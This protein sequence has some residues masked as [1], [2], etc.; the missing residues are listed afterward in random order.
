MI[1]EIFIDYHFI[2]YTLD[3]CSLC[4]SDNKY[5]G[6]NEFILHSSIKILFENFI[7]KSKTD[8][9][10]SLHKKVKY[11]TQYYSQKIGNKEGSR[12]EEIKKKCEKLWFFHMFCT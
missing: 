9:K 8:R 11:R 7:L 1:Q 12:Y 2:P 6:G 10:C 3:G 4:T 5:E